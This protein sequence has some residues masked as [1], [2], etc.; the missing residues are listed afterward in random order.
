MRSMERLLKFYASRTFRLWNPGS[1]TSRNYC[2]RRHPKRARLLGFRG[3]RGDYLEQFDKRIPGS[4]LPHTHTSSYNIARVFCIT[5]S[6]WFGDGQTH[7]RNLVLLRSRVL[8]L[9]LSIVR[10]SDCSANDL[11]SA[12]VFDECRG[13]FITQFCEVNVGS[14]LT[15]QYQWARYQPAKSFT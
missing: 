11:A 2:F 10:C 3:L 4:G 15:L 1:N 5:Q 7:C 8:T 6:R 14:L 12:F 13:F 9:V